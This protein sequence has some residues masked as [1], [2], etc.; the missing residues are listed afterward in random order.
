MSGA[1]PVT[2]EFIQ[3]TLRNRNVYQTNYQ[4]LGAVVKYMKYVKL[5]IDVSDVRINPFK[6][7]FPAEPVTY[8]M[9]ARVHL[10][11]ICILRSDI[12]ALK[13]F[14]EMFGIKPLFDLDQRFITIR[15]ALMKIYNHDPKEREPF[16]LRHY[17]EFARIK[18][19]SVESAYYVDFG[20]LQKVLV[21]EVY[22]FLGSRG[23]ELVPSD[24]EARLKGLTVERCQWVP[25]VNGDKS[26]Q[27]WKMNLAPGA[28]KNAKSMTAIREYRLGRTWDFWVDPCEKLRI[29]RLRREKASK[30]SSAYRALE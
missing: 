26:L 19:V 25:S 30:L 11:S 5:L 3:Q 20:V 27:H 22:G 17:S 24:K 28:W 15:K 7:P 1:D 12:S 14:H 6:L 10:V 18:G 13:W 16:R 4:Y 23:M 21:A 8:F 2:A 29:Y 9:A